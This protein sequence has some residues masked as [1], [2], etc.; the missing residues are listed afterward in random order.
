MSLFT[1]SQQDV[2]EKP[3]GTVHLSVHD[4]ANDDDAIHFYTGL[5]DYQKFQFVFFTL[6]QAVFSLN[7]F[8]ETK[9]ELDVMNQFFLSLIILKQHKTDFELSLL[10]KI[11]E[12]QV[13]NIFMTWI[14]FMKLQ[15]SKISQWPSKNLVRFFTP[16]DFNNKFPGTRCIIDR[17]EIPIE[18]PS[19][20]TSQ[21]NENET[22][23]KSIVAATPGG[24]ISY[25][26]STY[27]GS[28]SD[29]QIIEDCGLL[30]KCDPGDSIMACKDFDVQDILAEHKIKLNVP[31]FFKEKTKISSHT[32]LSDEK[33]SSE[34]VHVECIIGLKILLVLRLKPENI[35]THPFIV[36][37]FSA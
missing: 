26:S 16:I 10:F 31:K 15:W 21:Q 1:L 34:Q 20:P 33:I 2:L 36:S 37:I 11:S 14:R 23:V 4:L 30:S 35:E 24:L 5:E 28:T 6:G 19:T 32:V 13:A 9:P 12:K 3:I 17:I 22:T 27:A 25:V 8:Y 18:K 7:Y 29:R